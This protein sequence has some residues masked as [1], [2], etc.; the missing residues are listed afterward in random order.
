MASRGTSGAGPMTSA[1]LAWPRL[2]WRA[3]GMSTRLKRAMRQGL[4]NGAGRLWFGGLFHGGIFAGRRPDR[5]DYVPTDIWPGDSSRGAAIMLGEFRFAG[6]TVSQPATPWRPAGASGE[7]EAEMQGFDWLRDLRAVGGDASRGRARDLVLHWIGEHRRWQ[8]APWRPD[9]LGARLAS[10]IGHAE[11][12]GTGADGAFVEC[13]LDSLGRQARQLRRVAG[14]AKGGLESLLVLKGLIYAALCIP[15]ERGYLDRWL[16]ALAREVEAQILPDGGHVTRSPSLQLAVLRHL[17]ELRASLGAVHEEVPEALQH[18]IDRMCPMLRLFRHGD[19]GLA[20]FNDSNEEE[21]WLMDI[22]LAQAEARSKPL[23]SAPHAG[24]ERLAAN[25]TVVI[26]DVGAPTPDARHHAHAGTLGFELSVGKERLIVNCGAYAGLNPDWR[27]A[28]RA[29]AA[30]TTVTVGDL[31][32]AEFLPDG[33]V[34]SQP[35]RVGVVRR[36]ADGS[37]WVDAQH[38]GYV[39]LLGI[40]HR[41][42]LYLAENG[43]DL[44]GEDTLTGAGNQKFTVRF[45]LHPSVKASVAQGGSSVLLRLPS[46][47]GWRFRA[48]GGIANLQESV[49]LGVRGEIRRTEQI[50]IS[51]ATQHGF[52]QIKWK[53]SQLGRKTG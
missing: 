51:G 3:T 29:T 53:F 7:W 38:D 46:G 20:L 48:T 30:H 22:V 8:P 14:F 40:T 12:L 5:L 52:A 13:F 23:E 32:S 26:L 35:E 36:D 11:F 24:F 47:T 37:A 16:S 17:V 33:T 50:V 34:R 41:R 44:R 28:Q 15:D 45:H 1:Q 19:G 25:R 6:V 2:A 21:A 42:R 49:Y 39:R 4:V 10:W 18:A 43:G 27:D 9:V 31:N